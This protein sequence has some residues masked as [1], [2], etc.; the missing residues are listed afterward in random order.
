MSGHLNNRDIKFNFANLFLDK[1]RL[2][3]FIKKITPIFWYT[4]PMTKFMLTFF[5]NKKLIGLEIGVE[6]GLNAR[7]MLK[8][9]P[10]ERLYLIDPYSNKDDKFKEVSKYLAKYDNKTTFI[11]KTS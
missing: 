11:R 10:I 6:Y 1:G 3:A 5:K 2:Y 8:L 9:L 7:T 4:R